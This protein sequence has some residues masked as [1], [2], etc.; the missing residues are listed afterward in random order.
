MNPES[1]ELEQTW[2]TNIHEQSVTNAFLICGY[3]YSVSSYLSP[4]A[5][6]GFV[7]Y[8]GMGH[9]KALTIPFKNRYKYNSMLDY[10]RLEKKLFPWDNFNMVTYD[11]RLSKM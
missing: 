8:T 9:S 3:L 6:I 11:I 5:T 7:Y 10:N 4:D 2:E 1:L